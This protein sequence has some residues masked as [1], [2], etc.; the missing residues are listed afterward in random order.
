DS[1]GNT[2]TE[3]V[4]LSVNNINEK[5]TDIALSN[6]A[7]DENSKEGTVVAKLSAT[8]EDAGETFSYS[9]AGN[10]NF[11][12]EGN[13]VVVKEGAKL[14]FES[15]ESH[16]VDI[17]VT[18]SAGNAYTETVSFAVNDTND[19]P[20]ISV[21]DTSAI[22]DIA[23]VIATASD[24]DGTI[25][26]SSLSADHGIVTIDKDGNI[27]YTPDADYNGAD[28]VS[29]S[30]TD[31]GGATT[32][33]T[34]KLTID[35]T[36]DDPVAVNDS[37]F[38][39]VLFSEN[40]EDG[41]EGWSNNTVTETNGNA[42]DFLGQFGGT[43]G[44]EG[45]SKTYDFG[46]SH[47]GEKVTIEFDMYE[48]DSWDDE[49]FNVFVNAK[50]V[51]SEYMSHYNRT[52]SEHATDEQ[53]GGTEIDNIGNTSDK[54][55]LSH[56]ES[57]HYSFEATID[58]NG[59]VQ[60][61]FGSTLN[62]GINEE[63]WGI[64]N[65]A[66]T[67]GERWSAE[68]LVTNEDISLKISASSL[69]ANDSDVDGDLLTVESVTAS[70]KTHGTVEMDKDGNIVFTPE[71]NYHGEV[72][73]DYTI[74]DGHGGKDT[75]TVKLNV[76]SVNDAPVITIVD[77]T[78]TEDTAQVIASVAD[79]DGT[80]DVSTLKA[81]HG[82]VTIDQDG[83][84]NYTPDAD[85]NGA[86][87]V[88]LS[89][90]DNGGATTKQT[91]KLTIDPTQDTPVAV[92]DS[93]FNK[94][95]FSENFED[96]AEGWSNNTVTETNGNATDFLGQFGGTK[97]EEGISKT[98]DFGVSHAGENVT[99]E[100][101]MYEIDSWDDEQFNVFVNGKMVSSEYMS[102]YNRTLSVHATD[103]QDGGTEIDNIGNTSDK[104]Y[105]SHD[106]SHHYSF[107]ATVDKNGQVKL[108]FGS[109]IDEGKDDESWGIDNVAITAGEGWKAETLAT[110][111]DTSLIIKANVLLANDSDVDGDALTIT[112][113]TATDKT[114]G[115]V[116][117]DK[118]GNIVF[119]P[120]E[121]YNG[122]AS[123]SYT[124]SDGHGGKDSATVTLNVDSVND[125]ITQVID[126]NADAN[127]VSENLKAGAATGVILNALDVDGDKVTYSIENGVPF[128]VNEKGE[129]VTS[130]V[131]DFES[132]ESYTFDV[133]ATS[134]D[135]S[136]STESITIDVNNINEKPTDITLSA[137]DIDENSKEGTVVAKLSAT[138]EDLGEIFSYSMAKNDNFE[139]VGN[140]I[141]VKSG[142]DLD[143]ESAESHSVDITV[144]DSAGNAYTET[145]LFAVN[146]IN[147]VPVISVVDTSVIEDIAQVIATASDI[148][149][150]IDSSSLSADH[151]IV[152]IDKD[153][154]INYKPDA[155]YNGVDTVSLSVTDNGGATTKQTLKLT[156]DPTQDNPVAVND[157]THSF[158][159]EPVFSK[160]YSSGSKSFNSESNADEQSFSQEFG[161]EVTVSAWIRLDGN[162]DNYARVVE[163]GESDGIYQKDSTAITFRGGEDKN[164]IRGWTNA[165][166]DEG[167]RTPE[168]NF[169]MSAYVDDGK[170]HLITYT[171]DNTHAKLFVDGQEVDST[172]IS[173]PITSIDNPDTIN[174]GGYDG[175]SAFSFEGEIEGV[176][177]FDQALSAN[178]IQAVYE[179]GPGSIVAKLELEEDTSL[180]INSATLLANDTDVDGDALTITGVTATDKTHGTVE[181]DKDGNIV[182]TPEE[183]YNGDASFSYTISDGHGGKD[184]ATVTLHVDSVNDTITQVIDS[185]ADTNQV[186]ENLKAG[187]AT[188]VTLNALDA[189]GDKVTYS[190]ENGV[191]FS[192]NEKGEV[193][194]SEV[195]DFES[196]ESYTFDVMATS[197]DGSTSTK[198]ITIDV[199][200]INES[201]I[202]IDDTGKSHFTPEKATLTT[203][204]SFDEG[205]PVADVGSISSESNGQVGNAADFSGAKLSVDG[206]KLNSAEGAQTTVSMWMQGDPEG[207]WEMLTGSKYYDMVLSDGNIGFNTG[208]GDLF[209]SDAS[210][211][212]DGEWHHIVGVFTNGD[213]TQNQIYIDGESQSMSQIKGT[214]NSLKANIDS[215][216]G[217]L[218]FGSWGLN[219]SFTFTGSMDEV[220]VYDG[221]LTSGDVKS[222]F[223]TEVEHERWDSGSLS[224]QEDNSLIISPAELLTNDTD[225]DGDTLIISS[226][227]DSKHGSVEID[228]DGNIV[229]NPEEN[230][231]GEA[232]FSYTISDGNGGTD[233]ANV[234]LNVKSVNDA[235]VITVV[236]TTTTEDTSQIIA[237][238]TDID[239]TIDSSTLKAEYG[240]VTIDKD[241]N[242]TY[243][244]EADYQGV[245]TVSLSVTDN[246]GA[247]TSQ[248]INLTIDR[249]NV[250]PVAVDDSKNNLVQ[251]TDTRTSNITIADSKSINLDGSE[252]FSITVDVTP[253]GVQGWADI[254]F[255]KENAVE[256]AF[257]NGGNL[258]FAMRTDEQKWA[259]HTTDL[260]YEKDS[261]NI[262]KFSYD[263]KNVTIDNTNIMG[264]TNTYI[265]SYSGAI[266]DTGYGL[267]I[268]NRPTG[269]GV[270]SMDGEVDNISMTI[271][272]IE[273]ININ[274]EGENQLADTSG[275]GNDAVLNSGA[276]I[277]ESGNGIIVQEDTSHIIKSADLLNNDS[278]VDGDVL[279]ITTVTASG[280]THGSVKL[281]DDGNIVFTPEENYHGDASFEYTIS[282]GKGGND[283]ATV[284]LRVEEANDIVGTSN[285]ETLKGTDK[286]DHI[287]G[288]AGDDI[289]NAEAGNDVLN[290]GS[291]NDTAFGEEGNDTYEFN[292]FDGSDT[293]HGGQGGGWTDTIQLTANP[294]EGNNPWTITIDGNKVDYDMQAGVLELQP[295]T[296]G[297]ITM[298]DGSELN[299][300][301]VE[302]IQW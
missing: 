297:V 107:E 280:E 190:I 249:A 12:I 183:N 284:S 270:Y 285:S 240:T 19:V 138:D 34:I 18:D 136:T 152:T 272:G 140:Q 73:F 88:S 204:I 177:V 218:Y 250:N 149:G 103:E 52:W 105:L 10:D 24:I 20:V 117:M 129:V 267:M 96:G 271:D 247:T 288:E 47:A 261:I 188:G 269:G 151:G 25:D 287:S 87:T 210:E 207:G 90:T 291:G 185:N 42:T 277:V 158:F 53:D 86:D 217:T 162:V 192:V 76:E 78:V 231:Q 3:T 98:Y 35:P 175:G 224:M 13:Q 233:T 39:K 100:F 131:L 137:S 57:H 237:T 292:P 94:V 283:T 216:D 238:A 258:M 63:S 195:L 239:G 2:Y 164:T 254:I 68:T 31:N 134:V 17:T 155:D 45:I 242:I 245:D 208:H 83:N 264:E 36:Q 281:D 227:Q 49:Q 16:S 72:L 109:T 15:A 168:V 120:E 259:W 165:E 71:A 41:A 169:D 301:G 229:F 139:V 206:I 203:E 54:Y 67:A 172:V 50:M 228:D 122:D 111:E 257:N 127:Q 199:N 46:V 21:V 202:A 223:A 244:P 166:G 191:P 296:S 300:D 178:E 160:N 298:A 180:T 293:F 248:T 241:G 33:Q 176:G 80:I 157:S 219:N 186:S 221:E 226:V 182:F 234:K 197:A 92:N 58:K 116:E 99:I 275:H 290:G 282:D 294:D 97:G 255:N 64:D 145:I 26:S 30:I 38:N 62:G 246:V 124:I 266:I 101:D 189:D 276:S 1:A 150:T 232:S 159:P 93:Q 65:I 265:Q 60:L 113:V 128:S 243:T 61:G 161:T 85:Y 91:I 153:G 23:Q 279:S 133:M 205:V 37:Q 74:S 274:F 225:V 77:T 48:I 114:H 148:D 209:G 125:I 253:D 214:P 32:K 201:P 81:D 263:G 215:S 56:D 289:I 119:T 11:T 184:S 9:I 273:V 106:E 170:Y 211:L 147:D 179:T 44:E 5:P 118:D 123:F 43:K 220:K 173:N 196:V 235:P 268:G 51:S 167:G 8:D 174:I 187:A 141:K 230:Y 222:L 142:A 299:F 7:I 82:M 121:N 256:L 260:A 14:D 55:Y 156:I 278:D 27:N 144:T 59:Q 200:D 102:H 236:D 4:K 181:M 79:I 69:L 70:D 22:E 130:E 75:A 286:A 126:S 171:F 212:S 110:N 28:T 295:D 135:G 112:G 40:F 115:T 95:L 154:N 104:Y 302:T 262:I 213:L 146:D 163:F 198:S 251:L 84:I 89:V 132:V 193:V 6:S 252:N 143:F 29:L 66:I 108:G 194:T